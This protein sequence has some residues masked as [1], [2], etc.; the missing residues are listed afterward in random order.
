MLSYRQSC[1]IAVL[2]GVGSVSSE[3]AAL[4]FQ[5]PALSDDINTRQ[6]HGPDE[7][8][9]GGFQSYSGFNQSPAEFGPAPGMLQRSP[10]GNPASGDSFPLMTPGSL[11]GGLSPDGFNGSGMIP[12]VNQPSF[13]TNNSAFGSNGQMPFDPNNSPN[14]Q[15]RNANGNGPNGANLFGNNVPSIRAPQIKPKVSW[16][17][18][19][20]HQPFVGL[21]GQVA[22]PGV[23]EIERKGTLLADLLQSLGGL[24]KDS[25]EQFRIIRNGRPGQM[26][27]YSGAAQF[28]LMPG[29]LIVADARSSQIGQRA[30]MSKQ[31]SGESVQIGFV[32]LIDRPVVLK[33]RSEHASVSEILSIMRQDQGMASQ[34]KVVAPS[35][36]RGQPQPGPETSLV[37]ETVLIFP[38]NSV[39]TERLAMLPEPYMLKRE[40][41][42]AVDPRD[43][44][45]PQDSGQPSA[46]RGNL[47]P[48]VTQTPRSRSSAGNWSDSSPLPQSSQ[49]ISQPSVSAPQV[50]ADAPPPPAEFNTS[51]MRVGGVRGTPRRAA[52]AQVQ[53]ARDSNMPLAPPAEE[54]IPS[55][56]DLPTP[57]AIQDNAPVPELLDPV[58][59]ADKR[60]A[61]E[62]SLL[63]DHGQR[64]HVALA[65]EDDNS[66]K[67]T[68]DDL[69]VETA[70][71]KERSSWSIWPPILTAGIG[72]LALF[73]FSMSLR[74]RTSAAT[75]SSPTEI[76]P[77]QSAPSTV[78]TASATPRR[79]LLSAIIDNQLPTNEEPVPLAATMQFHGRPQPPKTIRMDS[80]HPL[81]RPHSPAAAEV[82]NLG[83]EVRT[84]E[85]R[86]E[87]NTT[88]P[89]PRIAATATQKFRID[90][91]VATGSSTSVTPVTKPAPHQPLSGSLDR[92]LSAVQKQSMQKPS[93]QQREERDA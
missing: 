65:K 69:D 75:M 6:I 90:R 23:Y 20:K 72:L 40:K 37:S 74:R 21:L 84:Q 4:A 29:D 58:P 33:L 78:R 30:S 67:L 87:M 77:A 38:P 62:P 52:S 63:K 35:S 25:S 34:I 68:A 55:P 45:Q 76:T 42:S 10:D 82:R 27:S 43:G 44:G 17:L 18:D 13:N 85:P 64:R 36:Q 53:I 71:T 15:W 7:W 24:A 70:T 50:L 9:G 59:S 54:T 93:N 8:V 39:K 60:R 14:G 81:P 16:A 3:T 80:R 26:T 5:I 51:P 91:N 83:S 66:I 1:L 61:A 73:G 57:E 11:P 88:T 79:D 22:R 47:S 86:V 92:A 46:P 28:E 32:N 48:N 89:A 31:P 41:D 56:R 19:E 12:P 49:R 2:C